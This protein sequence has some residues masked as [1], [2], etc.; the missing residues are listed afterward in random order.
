MDF[1]FEVVRDPKETAAMV[2]TVYD[3]Q[4]HHILNDTVWVT[5]CKTVA[6]NQRIFAYKH[7]ETGNTVLAVWVYD[8][9]ETD[10]AIFM[11]LETF[12]GEPTELW[13]T[14]LLPRELLAFRLQPKAVENPAKRRQREHDDRMRA[15]MSRRT[16][17]QKSREKAAKILKNKN[18]DFAAHMM[19]THQVPHQAPDDRSEELAKILSK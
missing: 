15:V 6:R 1:D 18:L 11:D 9:C 2:E 13:P 19:S 3:P 14:G 10:R 17:N 7:L 8:R 5:W 4:R 16:E 12:P